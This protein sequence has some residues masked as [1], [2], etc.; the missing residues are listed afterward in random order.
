MA[1]WKTFMVEPSEYCQRSLRRHWKDVSPRLDVSLRISNHYHDASVIVDESFESPGDSGRGLLRDGFETH[2]LW[3]KACSCGYQFI[4][5]DYWQVNEERLYRGIPT[6]KLHTLRTLPPGAIW[7]AKWLED[8]S[9]NPYAGPDSKVWALMMPSGSEWLIYGPASGGGK[10]TVEGALPNITVAPSI[11][12]VG[13]YHGFV[14]AGVITPDCEGR[15]FKNHPY[16][17]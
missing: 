3:P 16:T 14:K 5:D 6:G 10:W 11:H 1:G 4:E 8:I 7:R 17:A 15:I 2:P 9:P 13:S 12:Q